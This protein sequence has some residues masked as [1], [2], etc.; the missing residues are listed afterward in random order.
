MKDYE[1]LDNEMAKDWLD[2]LFYVS[3]DKIEETIEEI[4]VN[5]LDKAIGYMV[6]ATYIVAHNIEVTWGLKR[7]ILK[8]F[9]YETENG[10]INCYDEPIRRIEV[11]NKWIE[12]ACKI[13]CSDSEN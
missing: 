7:K 4:G 8:A 3:V 2:K 11:L 12:K 13:K 6:V 1:I 9:R 5:G 10:V